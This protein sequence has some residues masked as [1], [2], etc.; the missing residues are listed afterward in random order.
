[1]L[2][3]ASRVQIPG[4]LR[5]EARGNQL[6][7]R[8]VLE[9]NPR[10]TSTATTSEE[11]TRE[12][13]GPA[14]A[15]ARARLALDR[16][17]LRTGGESAWWWTVERDARDGRRAGAPASAHSGGSLGVWVVMM[18]AMM[19]P[20][21]SPTV[22]LYSRMAGHA[23][24]VGR[25]ARVRRLATCWRGLSPAL[26]AYGIYDVAH[27]LLR[28]TLAVVESHGPLGRGRNTRRR[29]GV[30]ADADQGRLPRQVPQPARLSPRLVA[31]RPIGR[32]EDG[33][34]VTARGASAAAGR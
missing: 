8:H 10:M 7:P 34:R 21:V 13:L 5:R 24:S 1:M 11:R 14:F 17:P 4:L 6:P 27:S 33:K 22:A 12:G 18:A 31:R 29:R 25:S 23:Q 2:K 30:R 32:V 20:S 28:G 15:A 19:F 16:A 9:Q 26:L 3:G